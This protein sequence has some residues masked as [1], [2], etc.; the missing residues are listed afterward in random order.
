MP[1]ADEENPK[2]VLCSCS[3]TTR[4][5]IIDLVAQGKDLEGIS[6]YSGALSGCGGC[7]WEINELV[8]ALNAKHLTQLPKP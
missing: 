8:N 4:G 2:E 5:L 6:R 7:E 1:G 3:G